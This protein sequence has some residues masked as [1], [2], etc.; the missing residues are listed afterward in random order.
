MSFFL[1]A[2]RVLVVLILNISCVYAEEKAPAAS[3]KETTLPVPATEEYH[4][5]TL[6]EATK[7]IMLDT[8]NKVLAA[9]TELISGKKIHVI[10][11]LTAT[12]HIQHIKIDA[13]T[14]KTLDKEKK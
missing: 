7:Q 12:G 11:I 10:K 4:P 13:V 5:V 8:K 2:A 6:D 14:G 3:T 9:K 1:K